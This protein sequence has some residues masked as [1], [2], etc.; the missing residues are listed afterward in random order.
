MDTQ[1]TMPAAP[2]AT[3]NELPLVS[4]R[5]FVLFPGS[6]LPILAERPGR[7]AVLQEAA[8]TSGTIA[9]VLQRDPK[10]DLPSFSGLYPIGVEARLLRYVTA[11]DGTHHAIVQGIG[12]IRLL[13]M[14]DGTEPRAV[15]VERIAEPNDTSTDI[16]ARFLQL[17]DRALETLGL[18]E[19]APPELAGA[20]Q[21]IDSPGQLADM[22]ASLMD[23][24]PAEKQD[25]LETIPL[26]GRLDRVL[27]KLAHRLEVLRLSADIGKR[28][29]ETMEG[30]QRE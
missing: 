2:P 12:R 17:R 8:R 29:R 16:E 25:V 22:V 1:S 30:R 20:V 18:L 10:D 24:T 15:R 5:Q 26:L 23:I 13:D 3:S 21:A 9:V 27:W 11:R 7:E 28:T 19:Q 6:V 14:V 4:V